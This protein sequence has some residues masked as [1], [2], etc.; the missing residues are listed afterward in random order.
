MDGVLCNFEKGVV[1]AINLELASE[2]PKNPKLAAA[3]IEDLGR[4]YIT[5]NDIQ[6]FSPGKSSAA[7]KYMYY[8]VHDDVDFWADLEW[9]PGGKQLWAY[10]RQFDPDILTSPMDKK[11]QNE[12]LEGKL[13]WVEKNLGLS[14]DK[15][16]FAH[17]KYKYAVSEDGKPNVLIDDFETKVKPFTEAGGIGILHLGANNTIKILQLLKDSD[18]TP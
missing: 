12:S 4:N 15:V 1:K 17:D 2:N 14:P 3:I 6:K 10:I 16:N 8:L 13:I 5:V 7:T 18:E 9:Q 11:G